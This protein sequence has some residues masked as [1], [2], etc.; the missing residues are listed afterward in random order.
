M[1]RSY[2]ITIH[3]GANYLRM[4]FWTL[5]FA[6]KYWTSMKILS[7]KILDFYENT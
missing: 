5:K 6:K 1:P 3:K 4:V 2:Y 7:P